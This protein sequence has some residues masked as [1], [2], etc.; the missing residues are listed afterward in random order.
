MF[1]QNS[2]RVTCH[3]SC[4]MCHM[5][6]VTLKNIYEYEYFF[7]LHTGGVSWWR[8]CYQWGLP[9]LVFGK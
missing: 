8:V 4:V 6:R 3:A 2:P 5:S 9:R 1:T 7:F